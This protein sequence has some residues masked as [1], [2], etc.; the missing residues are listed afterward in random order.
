MPRWNREEY[1][2]STHTSMPVPASEEYVDDLD[3][4]QL[5]LMDPADDDRDLQV[6]AGQVA[7][8]E[9]RDIVDGS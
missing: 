2:A 1:I 9:D 8:Q 6:P 4:N 7:A 3:P 5:E